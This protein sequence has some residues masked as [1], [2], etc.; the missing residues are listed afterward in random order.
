VIFTDEV[1]WFCNDCEEEVIDTD[2]PDQV[3][4]DSEKGEVGCSD[5]CVTVVDPQPIADPIW[6]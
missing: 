2:Y 6:R 4:S 1:I 3:T 5:G